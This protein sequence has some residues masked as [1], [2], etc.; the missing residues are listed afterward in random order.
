MYQQYYSQINKW[1]YTN[2]ITDIDN[3]MMRT[4]INLL[5]IKKIWCTKQ[6]TEGETEKKWSKPKASQ[7][8]IAKNKN[9]TSKENKKNPFI[10]SR[11][12]ISYIRC[13]R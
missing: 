4:L 7:R 11:V 1:I 9:E 2:N 10:Q 13:K 12:W 8:T 5:T 6:Q 3:G